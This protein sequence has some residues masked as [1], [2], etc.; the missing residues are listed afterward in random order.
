MSFKCTN[1][2]HKHSAEKNIS[3]DLP[4][5]GISSTYEDTATKYDP[6]QLLIKM[7]FYYYRTMFKEKALLPKLVTRR[8]TSDR[9]INPA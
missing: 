6:E 9:D 7:S 4:F 1:E 5:N 3:L 2:S 8:V